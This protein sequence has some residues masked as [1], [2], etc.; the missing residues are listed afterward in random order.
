MIF[1]GKNL[2]PHASQKFKRRIVQKYNPYISIWVW[3]MLFICL[4]EENR[5]RVYRGFKK[6]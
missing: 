3:G 5:I 4:L 6:C 2:W 1:P